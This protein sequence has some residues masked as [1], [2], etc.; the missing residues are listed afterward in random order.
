MGELAVYFPSVPEIGVQAQTNNNI[1]NKSKIKK[2]KYISNAD[3]QSIPFV[4]N[5]NI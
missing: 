1:N 4:L 2:Q 5:V 3:F